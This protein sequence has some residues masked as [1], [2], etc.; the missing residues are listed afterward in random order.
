[1]MSLGRL[2]VFEGPD[3]IGKSTILREI[4]TR[5][6]RSGRPVHRESFPGNGPGSLGALVYG[7]HHES[8]RHGVDGIS[9][10]ALQALHIAA[11]LDSIENTILPALESGEIVLLDRFWWSAWVYG[12][13]AK[14]NE[15][16]LEML[17][18]AEQAVWK[19]R[20]PEAIFLITRPQAFRAEHCQEQFDQY[21][22]LY[23]EVSLR[24]QGRYPVFVVENNDLDKATSFIFE[25][26]TQVVG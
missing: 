3:G 21:S 14:A 7:L 20:I 16:A 5:L 1:M 17:V 22:Q 23:R 10:L 19:E 9:P 13:A 18:K 24:E 4:A 25:R 8:S 6:E 11:H 2:I 12:T 26:V 15:A